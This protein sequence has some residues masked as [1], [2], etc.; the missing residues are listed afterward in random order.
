MELNKIKVKNY[1]AIT[2]R[3][4]EVARGVNLLIGDNGAG[5]SSMLEAMTVALSGM[6]E[7]IPGVF[8]K[9]IAQS[10]IHIKVMDKGDA[11]IEI[12]YHVPTEITTYV[13][14][15]SMEYCLKKY[16]ESEDGSVRT[17]TEDSG[18][19][20]KMQQKVNDSAEVLPLI[21]FQSDARVWQMQRTDSGKN[22]KKKLNDRRCGYINC[23]DYSLDIKGIQAWCLKMELTAFQKN[24]KIREYEAFKQIISKFMQTINGLETAPD[25]YYSSQLEEM[26]YREG[27]VTMPVTRLSAGYQSLLWIV[28]NL[29]Y[30]WAL[31]NPD[32]TGNVQEA[33]G[34][35]LI[36]EIDMHLH[37]KW[38]WN[39][40]KALEETFPHVQFILTTHSPIVISS[41]RNEHLILMND[42]QEVVYLENAYGYSVQDVLNFRQG[43]TEKPAQVKSLTDAF[44]LAL[45]EDKYEEAERIL[46]Q[47]ESMLG[48]E[49]ADVRAAAD[50]L[51]WNR[52]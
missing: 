44:Y 9:G 18:L 28:M 2:D 5:K 48:K 10:D 38:Q 34:I 27:D 30:R 22:L 3:E 1:K 39:I 17:K 36:D 41:C 8:Q 19:G 42:D 35:V 4:L 7:K 37:P 13:T 51:A 12:L 52:L 46:H 20:K 43:T 50:E 15:D 31:L 40:V 21:C 32:T 16:W 33:R 29:A 49:H 14:L 23:L 6:F 11:S 47:M 24:M 25:I 45:E 26:V